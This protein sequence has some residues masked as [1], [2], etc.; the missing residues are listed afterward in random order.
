MVVATC[1]WLE[2]AG[3]RSTN[4]SLVFFPTVYALNLHWR[5]ASMHV[6]RV[7]AL[8]AVIIWRTS[9]LADATRYDLRIDGQHTR[10]RVRHRQRSSTF[11]GMFLN[12]KG[13]KKDN[14]AP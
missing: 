10:H 1:V 12:G 11:I 3:K 2:R 13:Y 4:N 8:P 7:N 5:D 9:K 14:L 6:Q